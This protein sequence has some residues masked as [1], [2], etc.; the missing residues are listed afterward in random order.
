MSCELVPKEETYDGYKHL[1]SG[2]LLNPSAA[3][4]AALKALSSS[5]RYVIVVEKK[6]KGVDQADAFEVLGWKAGLKIASSVYD[7][8]ESDGVIKFELASADGY[9]E[10]DM[11][12]NLL[13]TDYATTQ[14]AFINKF[15]TV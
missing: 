15:A 9:E 7:S 11:T 6:W 14:T 4:K 13:E 2:V 5:S 3:N 12:L 10:P 8:K 1:F